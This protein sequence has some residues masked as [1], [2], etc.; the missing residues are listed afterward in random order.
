M[1]TD[2]SSPPQ[3]YVCTTRLE[4][5]GRKVHV[6]VA[7]G[8]RQLSFKRGSTGSTYTPSELPQN[9]M[10]SVIPKAIRFSY[11]GEFG[12]LTAQPRVASPAVLGADLSSVAAEVSAICS[13]ARGSSPLIAPKARRGSVTFDGDVNMVSPV[14]SRSSSLQ[15]KTE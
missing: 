15:R 6:P 4:V 5:L 1:N 10:A 8:D 12:A 14:V 7:Q 11:D 2:D 3:P 13:H 9:L